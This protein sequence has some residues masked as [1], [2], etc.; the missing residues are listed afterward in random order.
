[1]SYLAVISFDL[2]NASSED[3]RNAYAALA[4][5]GLKSQLAG[6]NR[7]VDLPS[8]TCA[9]EFQ[10]QSSGGV[11]DALTTKVESAFKSKRLKSTFFLSVGGDWTWGKR[12]T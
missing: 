2:S 10:G 5:I 8:T 1:M 4:T 12:S 3:Y 9:G 6:T 11:R 7:P